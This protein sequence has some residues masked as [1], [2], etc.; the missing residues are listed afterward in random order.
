MS[1]ESAKLKPD[2]ARKP[3][4]D[5]AKPGAVPRDFVPV[6]EEDLA[7]CLADPMWRLCSGQLYKIMVKSVAKDGEAAWLMHTIEPRW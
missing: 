3:E 5:S 7:R 2:L 1:I 6:T 4:S